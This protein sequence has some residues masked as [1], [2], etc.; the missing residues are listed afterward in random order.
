MVETKSKESLNQLTKNKKE[1]SR[2]QIEQ[3]QSIHFDCYGTT[4]TPEEAENNLIEIT[5]L[6]EDII[7][8][9]YLK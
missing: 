1:N 4:I 8:I 7:K 5:Q 9:N 2:K 3:F 6:L